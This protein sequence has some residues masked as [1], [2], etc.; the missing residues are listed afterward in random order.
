[1]SGRAARR[2]FAAI[3]ALGALAAAPA[4]SAATGSAPTASTGAA[5][6]TTPSAATLTGTVNPNGTATTYL[7]QYGAS[8]GYGSQTGVVPVGSGTASVNAS[9]PLSGLT[10]NTTYHF[11]IVATSA[12]GTTDG[13][14]A[15]FTTAPAP[16]V[17]VT[18][19]ASNVS[20]TGAVLSGTVN[21]NGKA[22]SYA[23][24]YGT[25]TAYGLET[26]TLSAGSG[27]TA[28]AVTATATGLLSGT[29]YHYR[30]IATNPD[31]TSKGA[32]KTLTTTHV[33]P[34][35]T[36]GAPSVV[37]SDSAVVTA[38]VS[39]AGKAT[40]YSFQYGATTAYG[41]QTAFAAAGSATGS[42]KVG[43]TIGGLAPGTLYHYRIVATSSGGT[44]EGSDASFVTT[45]A[46]SAPG[47]PMP[48]VFNTTAEAISAN[49]AQ[50]NGALDPTASPTSWYFEY[51]LSTAY[52]VRTTPQTLAA[53][54]PHAINVRLSGLEA[55]A[56]FHYRLVAQF[57]ATLYVGPDATFTTKAPL[58][59][60]PSALTLSAASTAR[61]KSTRIVASGTLRTPASAT[62]GC[63]GSVEIQVDRAPVTVALT[64]AP[65]G[66]ACAYRATVT[67]RASTL[68]GT[69]RL[70][71]IARFTGNATL[72]PLAARAVFVQAHPRQG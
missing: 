17:V 59:A 3:A 48:A 2:A 57:G 10:A 15:T 7:F 71:V 58:R 45:A 66:G 60:T 40:T 28:V 1:M 61:G 56:T 11:R 52:G 51:G 70:E 19:S 68:R 4:I 21:P 23:F 39:A 49:G 22:A 55:A 37:G 25:S 42:S 32:D 65:L 53:L 20:A 44:V 72:A 38:T 29:S 26:A 54:G 16:P 5:S 50:L 69:R 27:E 9:A 41:S 14:D 13:A 8:T 30:L 31:G 6:Q 43:A 47:G 62:G 18:G 34:S 12:N 67:L 36:T 33:A 35:A 24:E 46:T 63:N 64:N